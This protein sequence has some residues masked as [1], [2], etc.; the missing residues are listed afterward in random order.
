MNYILKD[1]TKMSWFTNMRVVFEAL[2]GLQKNYSWLVTD[3]ECYPEIEEI[4]E[5]LIISGEKLTDIVNRED[6]Q[7]VWAVFTGFQKDIEIDNINLEVVPY[8]RENYDFWTDAKIQHPQAKVE[9]DCCDSS[10][11]ALLSKDELIS[12]KFKEYFN[13]SIA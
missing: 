5:G 4:K 6:I 3:I 10:Y 9:V 13:E 11:V 8:I 7:F 2:D 12:K 1:T